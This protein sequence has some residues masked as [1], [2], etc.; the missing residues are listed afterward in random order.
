MNTLT[1]LSKIN[2]EFNENFLFNRAQSL[3]LECTIAYTKINAGIEREFFRKE[4]LNN[5]RVIKK[6]APNSK[7]E[8]IAEKILNKIED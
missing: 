5:Y 6:V 4:I 7:Y 3:A 1:V 8:R 2:K